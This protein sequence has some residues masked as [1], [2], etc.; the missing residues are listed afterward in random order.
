MKF[1]LYYWLLLIILLSSSVSAISDFTITPQYNPYTVAWGN[2]VNTKIYVQCHNVVWACKCQA[3]V[4]GGSYSPIKSVSANGGENSFIMSPKTA[5]S[6]GIDDI[7]QSITVR[8]NDF[9]YSEYGYDY[10]TITIEWPTASQE[11]T[12]NSASSKISSASSK[13]NSASAAIS[14]AIS[15]I[16]NGKSYG[17]SCVGVSQA[18][19]YLQTAQSKKT[20]ASSTLSSA[21]SYWS[22]CSYT[23]AKNYATNAESTAEDS[24]DYANDAK[25]SA[26]DAINEYDSNMNEAI[27]DISSAKSVIESAQMAIDGAQDLIEQA[28][29]K[30][31]CIKVSNIEIQLATAVESISNAESSKN[32]AESYKSSCSFAQVGSYT[33]SAEV[34]ANSAREIGL[35]SKQNIIDLLAEYDLQKENSDIELN[36]AEQLI[37]GARTEIDKVETKLKISETTS[38]IEELGLASATTLK[39]EAESFLSS[40]NEEYTLA[41]SNYN[42]CDFDA[43]ILNSQHAQEF[44]NKAKPKATASSNKID[45]ILEEVQSMKDLIEDE[46]NKVKNKIDTAENIDNTIG[47]LLE[48]HPEETLGKKSFSE[49]KAKREQGREK[50]RAAKTD[51]EKAGTDFGSGDCSKTSNT[52]KSALDYATE[53]EQII[54]DSHAWITLKIQEAGDCANR[55]NN[56]NAEMNKLYFKSEYGRVF[57]V[58]SLDNLINLSSKHMNLIHISNLQ[59]EVREAGTQSLINL[60]K[61][62]LRLDEG[63]FDDCVILAESVRD[64]AVEIRRKSEEAVSEIAKDMQNIIPILIE[65]YTEQNKDTKEVITSKSKYVVTNGGNIEIATTKARENDVFI[66]EIKSAEQIL[67]TLSGIDEVMEQSQ[68]IAN[69][70]DKI[71]DNTGVILT[72]V[73]P[74]VNKTFYKGLLIGFAVAI[75]ITGSIFGFLKI[76]SKKSIKDKKDKKK[77]VKKSTKNKKKKGE[78]PS[79][80]N[81]FKSFFSKKKKEQTKSKKE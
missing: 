29:S 81:K 44:A 8:C 3:K 15:A 41:K 76:K 67:S 28:K 19:T 35:S 23:N 77:E 9:I 25:D 14:D 46:L 61:A 24:I 49:A 55:I 36:N 69:K 7:P 37:D 4:E 16:N 5:P 43:S 72:E 13:I 66:E 80:E 40:A 21:N 50:I 57:L 71:E 78:K 54:T 10:T 39:S 12:Y 79:N 42:T 70:V 30:S 2:S 27:S 53:A 6:C 17:S 20:S 75:L 64:S 74:S 22:S 68:T 59:S 52:I 63:N 45:L 11:S 33:T 34:D 32:S 56:A 18:E 38:C 1:K 62:K 58:D 26:Q 47:V 60:D 73:L 48:T 31:S 51:Y 65:T